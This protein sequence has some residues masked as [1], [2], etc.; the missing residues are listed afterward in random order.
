ME[1]L[2]KD[3]KKIKHKLWLKINVKKYI[4]TFFRNTNDKKKEIALSPLF[5]RNFKFHVIF[6]LKKIYHVVNVICAF[7]KTQLQMLKKNNKNETE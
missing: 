5:L 6:I 3:Y 4:L 1:N 2:R 7:F